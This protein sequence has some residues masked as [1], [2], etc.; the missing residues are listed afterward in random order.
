[1]SINLPYDEQNFPTPIPENLDRAAFLKLIEGAAATSDAAAISG[2]ARKIIDKKLQ[3]LCGNTQTDCGSKGTF[4]L[5][6]IDRDESAIYT[7]GITSTAIAG[8]TLSVANVSAITVL[9]RYPVVVN[10]Y[11]PL[12]GPESFDALLIKAKTYVEELV[13]NDQ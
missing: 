6:I 11:L 1:M 13:T 3:E 4:S 10:V 8:K 2:E 12:G 5:G 7:A 9:Q